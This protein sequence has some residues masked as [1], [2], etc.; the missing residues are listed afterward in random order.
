MRAGVAQG[1]SEDICAHSGS[2]RKA[3]SHLSFGRPLM[4]LNPASDEVLLGGCA[5]VGAVPS[6]YAPHGF[7]D[8]V[9]CIPQSVRGGGSE[10]D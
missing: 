10:G 7:Y 2:G 4:G 8:V 3:T 5:S 9:S 1:G 6:D